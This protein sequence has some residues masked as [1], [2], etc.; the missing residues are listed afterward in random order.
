MHSLNMRMPRKGRNL[1]LQRCTGCMSPRR[2]RMQLQQS[3]QLIPIY[4]RGTSVGHL[5]S[6]RHLNLR[7]APIE[8][9]YNHRNRDENIE[10]MSC[11]DGRLKTGMK[12]I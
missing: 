4:M 2:Q 1:W 5:R 7:D 12:T 9:C 6:T 11:L 8:L 10:L 3:G